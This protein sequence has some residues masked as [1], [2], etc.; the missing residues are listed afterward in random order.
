MRLCVGTS[1]GIVILDPARSR[2][3]LMVLADPTA[4]WCMSQDCADPS[5]IYA[6]GTEHVRG[7]GTLAR[8]TDGGRSWTDISPSSA[9]EEE[10]WAL[11]A[12]PAVKD[13]VFVGTSHARLFRSDDRGR[14]FRECPGF[15]K[16]PGRERWSFPPPPHIPHV[17]SISF[18]PHNPMAMYV[19]VEEGGVYRT[20][21]GGATFESLNEG[22]YDDI[23]TVAIDPRDSRR[24]YATTGGGFFLSENGGA[25]WRRI[26]E[27]MN[28]TYTVPLL[29]GNGDSDTVFTA[30]AAGPPPTWSIG[31]AGADAMLFRSDDHGKSFTP[32]QA[33]HVWGRGMVMRLLRDPAG[34]AFFGVTNDGHVIRATERCAS[35]TSVSEQLPP[36]YDLVTL[37]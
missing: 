37:P 22:L 31:H 19:G 35:V 23:H 4:V 24:L 15:Q 3:P 6:G 26:T 33:D 28:R 9:R 12:S 29:V 8:S 1:K 17:R 32:I 10:V 25:S 16:I 36:A 18:D 2:L 27:G 14:S 20:R 34:G 11:A 21:D 5:V 30:A 13:Q 7:K